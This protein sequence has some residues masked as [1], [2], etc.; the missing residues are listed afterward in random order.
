MNTQDIWQFLSTQGVDFAIKLLTAIV[1]WII[2]R[3]LLNLAVN[4][5][6][7]AITAPFTLL[8]RALGGAGDDLSQVAF[9]PGS[10]RLDA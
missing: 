10:A 5:I 3:W 2:G 6:G 8:A 7:K 4:L 1:A 9:A